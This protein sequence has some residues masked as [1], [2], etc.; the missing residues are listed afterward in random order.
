LFIAD[1]NDN[2]VRKVD[3]NGI[4]T[5]IAGKYPSNGTFSGDGGQATNADL[6]RPNNLAIAADGTLYIADI[7]NER[8]RRVLPNGIISTVAG[9]GMRNYEGDGMLATS[10]GTYHPACVALDASG[11]LFIA[12]LFNQRVREVSNGIITTVVGKGTP[13]FYGDGGAAT[14]ASLANP[15]GIAFDSAGNLYIADT[16]NKRIRKVTPNGIISTVVGGGSNASG[17]GILATNAALSLPWSV[18]VDT[19]GNLFIADVEYN[20]VRKVTTN[21]LIFTVAG[22][23]PAVG[24]FGGD[25]GPAT[26]AFLND[27]ACVALDRAG[28]LYIADWYNNR[29]RE[30]H[31]GGFPTLTLSNVTVT[32]FGVYSVVVTSPSGSVTNSFTLNVV[33]QPKLSTISLTD[34]VPAF[35]WT[36]QSNLSYQVQYAT[37]LAVPVWMDLGGR[38]TATNNST[39]VTDAPG[40]DLNRFYRVKWAP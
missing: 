4:I 7:F 20:L 33:T 14:N 21:G 15:Q 1:N 13:L 5:T 27:P 8:V 9:D 16:Y 18:C 25:G 37:N 40:P 3:T 10:T 29:V 23:F 12:D 24:T 6:Y 11:N 19:V 31:L 32:N 38:I 34:G 26:N 28:N 39:S 35:T 30:V 22:K 17:E 36:S 2:V